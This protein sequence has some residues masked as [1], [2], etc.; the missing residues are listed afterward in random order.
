MAEGRSADPMSDRWRIRLTS[1]F[2]APACAG[3]RVEGAGEHNES[4]TVS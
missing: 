1:Q 2:S 4:D 3:A